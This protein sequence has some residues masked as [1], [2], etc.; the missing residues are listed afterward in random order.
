[1]R[2]NGQDGTKKLKPKS[3]KPLNS[4]KLNSRLNRD[5]SSL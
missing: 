1:L 3:R 5:E 4:S 2:S